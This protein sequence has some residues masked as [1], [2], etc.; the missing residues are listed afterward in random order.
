[1][2]LGLV[3]VVLVLV[4]SHRSADA[5]NVVGRGELRGSDLGAGWSVVHMNLSA[6]GRS[7]FGGPAPCGAELDRQEAAVAHVQ[8]AS[9][10]GVKSGKE[11]LDA[12]VY[13]FRSDAETAQVLDIYRSESYQ[14][15]AMQA[16]SIPSA[17]ARSRG[18]TT[19]RTAVVPLV[20]VLPSP[21]VGYEV[22]SEAET[23]G[24]TVYTDVVVITNHSLL[25]DLQFVSS[26]PPSP[27]FVA[28]VSAA[29]EQ[30]LIVAAGGKTTT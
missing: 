22:S 4:E 29:A 17:L 16:V 30:R 11:F 27:G 25:E 10:V 14:A 3:A 20:A 19:L 9:E 24:I 28:D 23:L 21:S 7:T 1:M 13:R 26:S 8:A 15:C 2:A 6:S 5:L 18:V 12:F